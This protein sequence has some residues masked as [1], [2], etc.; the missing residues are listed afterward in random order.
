M[1]SIPMRNYRPWRFLVLLLT[2]E[3]LLVIQP[4]VRGLAVRG[5]VFDV[6]YSL[7]LVAS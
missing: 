5:P 6:L 4:M 3:L 2:L 7:V 1:T